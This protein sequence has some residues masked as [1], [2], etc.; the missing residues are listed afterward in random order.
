MRVVSLPRGVYT[1]ESMGKSADKGDSTLLVSESQILTVAPNPPGST[2]GK[3]DQSVW[4][5]VVVSADDF[6]PAPAPRR[7]R[8]PRWVILA[9]LGAIAVAAGVIV[10]LYT[11]S[12]AEPPA[13]ASPPAAAAVVPVLPDAAVAPVVVPAADAAP[14]IV[15][16]VDAAV[17]DAPP[18]AAPAAVPEAIVAPKPATARP[19][20]K[21]PVL[22]K[23]V[24]PKKKKPA[25]TTKRRAR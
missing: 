17:A 18:D 11:S 12:D 6:A 15:P 9:V 24:V 1:R 14:A 13:Q 10:A 3:N 5:G 21:K 23:K 4:K 8:A 19:V 20:S 25:T 22:K 16:P 2:G 7:S